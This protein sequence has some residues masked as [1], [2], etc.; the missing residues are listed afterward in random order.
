MKKY[1]PRF[2]ERGT[3]SDQIWR[4]CS[5]P[6]LIVLGRQ[7]TNAAREVRH[8]ALIHL[9]RI[10]LGQQVVPLANN[11]IP[12]LRET[13]DTIFERILFPLL[14]ELLRP[15]IAA[16]DARG[17]PETRL[18]A[19]ALLCKVFVA[20]EV[21]STP[22]EVNEGERDIRVLWVQILDLLDRLM[23]VDKRDQLV[24]LDVLFS[25]YVL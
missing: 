9:Q 15:D 13:I 22:R 14:D 17:M 11:C 7:S 2:V 8:A 10:L 25:R 18:R 21:Q 1:I 12:P 23:N 24:S 6:L 5:L 4:Q 16:R 19:S 3:P 20:L